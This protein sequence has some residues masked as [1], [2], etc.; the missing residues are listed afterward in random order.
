M[1]L[2]DVLNGV[3]RSHLTACAFTKSS[4]M[5]HHHVAVV[6][7]SKT[8][9]VLASATNVATKAGSIHAEVGAIRQLH[10]RLKDGVLFPREVKRG[11]MVL[12]LRINARGQ[13]M[14]AKPCA[15]CSAAMQK[16]GLVKH[17]AWSN[18]YGTLVCEKCR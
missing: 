2:E 9:N 3:Q 17:V 11:T 5:N 13:L 12:S 16:S 7:S 1:R 10:H 18:E 8:G 15:N 4:V 14:F 6:L